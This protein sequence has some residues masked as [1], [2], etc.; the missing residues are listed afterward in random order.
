MRE[1][2]LSIEGRECR[3]AG[4]LAL[5]RARD[6]HPAIVLT[7]RRTDLPDH[8][9][10]ISF[11]GGQREPAEPL[12]V[13][14]LRETE[15]EIGLPRTKVTMIG[16]LTPLYIPPSKFCVHPFLGATSNPPP[17]SPTDKEVDQILSISLEVLLDPTTRVVEPWDLH[18]KQ[19]DVPYYEAYEH[20]IWGA[21]AMMLAEVLTLVRQ[22]V[23]TR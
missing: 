21:T 4:V 1:H 20:K 2:A 23:D 11:P 12:S 14:A 13:T 15:E 7:V 18:G 19:V 17:L 8:G 5:L 3:E 16:K 9:G 10:Q 22:A 6:E